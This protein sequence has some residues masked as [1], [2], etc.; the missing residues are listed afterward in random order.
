MELEQLVEQHEDKLKQHDKELSRLN[1]MSVEMQ[2]QMNDGLTRVDESNR[3]L[4]EQNTRQSE[5]NA[6]ILQAV[7][8]GNESSDEHQFQ[9]KLLDKTNFWKLIFGIGGASAA[10]YTIIMEVIKLIK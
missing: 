5:Q 1:D 8:K 4:R 10:I 6:Q 7:I 2:K 9:L 3:F